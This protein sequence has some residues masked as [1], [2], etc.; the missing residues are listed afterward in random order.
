MIQFDGIQPDPKVIHTFM[1][2]EDLIQAIINMLHCHDLPRVYIPE[3]DP[4]F[5]MGYYSYIYEQDGKLMGHKRS[6]WTGAVWVWE[7]DYELT[8]WE[9][10]TIDFIELFRFVNRAIH[11]V[12]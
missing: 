5:T 1:E 6:R 11:E 3:D 2:K 12:I 10:N 9:L 7:D 4:I 8:P